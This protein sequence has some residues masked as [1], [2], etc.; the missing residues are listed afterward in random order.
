MRSGSARSPSSAAP[1]APAGRMG[2]RPPKLAHS[3]SRSFRSRAKS[4]ACALAIQP[5]PRNAA[6][7][8]ER[9]YVPCPGW[10]GS[11]PLSA[12]AASGASAGPGGKPGAS[13]ACRTGAARASTSNSSQNHGARK[14]HHGKDENTP[15][16]PWPSSACT[17]SRVMPG[18]Q[19]SNAA[20]GACARR[21]SKN[22]PSTGAAMPSNPS[23][24]TPATPCRNQALR[25]PPQNTPSA[26][27]SPTWWRGRRYRRPD[28]RHAGDP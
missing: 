9:R 17:A 13:T 14:S 4:P 18:V 2:S 12:G 20:V 3:L 5:C 23:R 1:V 28:Q 10:F 11:M 8:A 16:K 26:C 19:A 7:V 22:A 27:A 25:W 21:P 15:A 6:K 24:R